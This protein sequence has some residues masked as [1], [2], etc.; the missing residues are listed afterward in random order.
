M[1]WPLRPPL[2]MVQPHGARW[3]ASCVDYPGLVVLADTPSEAHALLA[4]EIRARIHA[5]RML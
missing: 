3:E 2:V 1:S 5:S 4:D